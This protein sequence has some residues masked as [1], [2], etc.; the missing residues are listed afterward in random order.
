MHETVQS[1]GEWITDFPLIKFDTFE[2]L[3]VDEIMKILGYINKTNCKN[4]PVNLRK[5]SFDAVSPSLALIFNDIL[6]NSFACGLFPSSATFAFIRPQIKAGK[7]PAQ[8][9]SYR[10][11]HNT[12]FLSKLLESACLSQ[13]IVHMR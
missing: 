7:D 3:D 9:S 11:F 8:L 6:S 1:N 2:Q 5:L 4:D 13:L 12:S 10:T